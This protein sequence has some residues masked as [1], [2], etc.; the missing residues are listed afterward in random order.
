MLYVLISIRLYEGLMLRVD[1]EQKEVRTAEIGVC[2]GIHMHGT[3]VEPFLD[4]IS[5]ADV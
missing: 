1:D 4:P 5:R 3:L 2:R